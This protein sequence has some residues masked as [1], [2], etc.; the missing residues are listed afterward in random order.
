MLV[1]EV[2]LVVDDEIADAFGQWLEP[3]IEEMLTFHGF[4][5]AKWWSRIPE[6]EGSVAQDKLWTI[7]YSIKSRKDLERYFEVNASRMREDGLL[8]FGGR[9]VATRRILYLEQ[10]W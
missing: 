10:K 1:Y 6:D 8:N 2:N 4:E 5:S 9:F 7:Q 3:H